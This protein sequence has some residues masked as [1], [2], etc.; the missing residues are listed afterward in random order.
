MLRDVFARLTPRERPSL[1]FGITDKIQ[2]GCGPLYVTINTDDKGL[3]EVFARIGKSG[4]CATSQAEA[5]GRMISLA[6][7]A[8]VDINSI[9]DQ[10]KGIRC[11]APSF[12]KGGV[13]LSCSDGV[14]KVL[15]KNIDK[16]PDL[17]GISN[18]NNKTKTTKNTEH[19][20]KAGLENN[21]SKLDLGLCPECPDCGAMLEFK[22]GCAMCSSCGFSRC[23]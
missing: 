2:T 14:A 3:C 8:G 13:V 19:D 23:N 21:T 7:R 16:I 9:I 6:L 20:M 5:T 12:G 10:L 4:G 11:P 22:E 18:I 1:T 15:E 17:L